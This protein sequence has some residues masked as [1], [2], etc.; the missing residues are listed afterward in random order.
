MYVPHTS[1]PHHKGGEEGELRR[2][3]HRK[4]SCAAC[5]TDKKGQVRRELTYRNTRTGITEL[6][7]ILAGYGECTAMLESTG[8]LWL[9]TY[10]TLEPHGVPVKLANPLK[11][12]AIAQARIKTRALDGSLEA[13]A[14]SI[15]YDDI[16]TALR[17]ME[18]PLP[19]V[20]EVIAAMASIPHTVLPVDAA[21][22]INAL[23][24]YAKH[25]GPR[26]LHYFDSYHIATALRTHTPLITSD[27][28][29]IDNQAQLGITAVDL[30]RY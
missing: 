25:G 8:N 10:E 26:R 21:T 2:D 30:R 11:T 13:H 12:R 3:R 24:I 19:R 17:S 20:I 6:A 27:R 15:V 7:E 1:Q 16:V 29:I 23:R 14:S 28:Y 9:K 22:T 18:I 5:V 4:K